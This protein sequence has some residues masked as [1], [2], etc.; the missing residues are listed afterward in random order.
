M[1]KMLRKYF[2]HLKKCQY[3][4]HVKFCILQSKTI[5]FVC[6]GFEGCFWP[7]TQETFSIPCTQVCSLL[8][9]T[10]ADR[11]LWLSKKNIFFYYLF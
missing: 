2:I 1:R 8:V 4:F 6:N 7:Y 3:N 11:H 5:Y 10:S 9:Y